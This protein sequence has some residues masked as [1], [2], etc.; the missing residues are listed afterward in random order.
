MLWY[1]PRAKHQGG[2]YKSLYRIESRGTLIRRS[3]LSGLLFP[4]D[5]S[6]PGITPSRGLLIPYNNGIS[7][8][9]QVHRLLSPQSF[10]YHQA[11][12]SGKNEQHRPFIWLS[13]LELAFLVKRLR[14]VQ[15][16]GEL[17]TNTRKMPAFPENLPTR[18]TAE[19]HVDFVEDGLRK[20]LDL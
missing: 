11:C 2:M 6:F 18:C 14:V 10:Q 17:R 16:F 19:K 12:T 3:N 1:S 4:G 5:H 15:D 7:L 8:W 20:S 13:N 9:I